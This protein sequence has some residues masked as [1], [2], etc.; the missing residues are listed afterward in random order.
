MLVLFQR[1]CATWRSH[2]PLSGPV[3]R[4]PP[5]VS[6]LQ[7]GPRL[8]LPLYWCS[9]TTLVTW[10]SPQMWQIGRDCHLAGIPLGKPGTGRLWCMRCIGRGKQTEKQL[11]L[12]P[13][14]VLHLFRWTGEQR[15]SWVQRYRGRGWE[16]QKGAW[17][18]S[19]FGVA[20]A[21]AWDAV[22]TECSSW[23]FL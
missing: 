17:G 18:P 8:L 11:P 23:L 15:P 3:S 2:F 1:G 20:L 7:T 19:P 5:A 6:A 22:M 12:F 14:V 4:H 13:E 21:G 9:N 16:H 10:G